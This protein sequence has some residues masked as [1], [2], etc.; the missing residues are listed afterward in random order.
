MIE[1]PPVN[2]V[3]TQERPQAAVARDK[4]AWQAGQRAAAAAAQS[5]DFLFHGDYVLFKPPG[6]ALQLVALGRVVGA[7]FGGANTKDAVLD[8]T[9]YEHSA[10][11][12][13]RGLFGTFAAKENATYDPATKG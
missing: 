8:I 2:P 13:V 7:P 10:A 1:N 12:G 6:V 4:E 5:P 9:E 3:V 11:P